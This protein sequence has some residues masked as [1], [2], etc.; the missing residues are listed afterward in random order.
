MRS[1]AWFTASV[2]VACAAAAQAADHP[3]FEV[4]SVK[5]SPPIPPRTY[6]G[7]ARG[8]PGTADPG[9]ITWTWAR[10]ID[11]LTTAYD[12]KPYQINGPAWINTERYDIQ[13][14]LPAGA[15]KD[16]VRLMWQNL[17]AERFGVRL[18]HE[19]KEFRVEELV[20]AKGGSKLKE[21]LEDATPPLTGEP[22]KFK[23]GV[24]SS[25]GFVVTI[26]PGAS[27][28]GI[29][30]ISRAQPLSKLTGSLGNL[31]NHPVLDKTGLTGNYDFTLEFTVDMARL[32]ATPGGADAADAASD[33]G[34]DV[35]AALE[36][37]LGLKL[38]GGR[39]RLDVLVIEKADKTPTEN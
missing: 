5:P 20:I 22:P 17:L 11:L 19:S 27:K 12:V 6:L 13:V 34:S 10:F 2:L 32:G 31:V 9:Q 28:A 16:A 1:I 33:P 21:S 24:L 25:P 7:P 39:A 30:A 37:Q 8:G 29:R 14:K 23:D 35:E 26:T 18:R 3:A 15:T 38:A 36:D 4:A